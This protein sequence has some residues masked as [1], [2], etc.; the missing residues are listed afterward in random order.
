LLRARRGGEGDR[1]HRLRLPRRAGCDAEGGSGT[2]GLLRVNAMRH[3]HRTCVEQRQDEV[4][5]QACGSMSL[6]SSEGES[7]LDVATGRRVAWDLSLVTDIDAAGVGAL[8]GA[9]RRLS[10]RGGSVY[11]RAASRAVHRVAALAAID[12]MVPGA[13]ETRVAESPLCSAPCPSADPLPRE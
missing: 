11:V 5:V 3:P 9:V 13:W 6:Q 2:F 7:P 4:I 8:A 1:R 12:T 10:E